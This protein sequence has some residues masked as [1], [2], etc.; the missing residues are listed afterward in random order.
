MGNFQGDGTKGSLILVVPSVHI[1]LGYGRG[2]SPDRWSGDHAVHNPPEIL[3]LEPKL[4]LVNPDVEIGPIKDGDCACACGE[5]IF[6]KF[7]RGRLLRVSVRCLS[8][9]GLSHLDELKWETSHMTPQASV[10]TIRNP[11]LQCLAHQG[12]THDPSEGMRGANLGLTWRPSNTS[13]NTPLKGVKNAGQ[14]TGRGSDH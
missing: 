5:E 12:R 4:H 6:L 9:K 2:T 14:P 3:S 7:E 10:M 13:N 8:A 11:W 1:H